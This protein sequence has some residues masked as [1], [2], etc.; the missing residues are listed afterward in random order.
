MLKIVCGPDG[1]FNDNLG[2]VISPHPI[3]YTG[4]ERPDAIL[5]LSREGVA[6]RQGIFKNM[7]KEGVVIAAKGVEIPPAKGRI[8]HV[9]FKAH[10]IKK[11]DVAFAALSLLAIKGDPITHHMIEGALRHMY[12]GKRLKSFLALL[13]S[14]SNIRTS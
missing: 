3:D 6:R 12:Q 8:L 2:C 14:A 7:K 13:R 10:G 1:S 11:R 5:A 4:V 9:A